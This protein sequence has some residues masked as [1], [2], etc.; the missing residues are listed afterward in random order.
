MFHQKWKDS[1]KT[2]VLMVSSFQ[3]SRNH[4]PKIGNRNSSNLSSRFKPIIQK[5]GWCK[6]S[7]YSTIIIGSPSDTS[8]YL[9]DLSHPKPHSPVAC[10]VSRTSKPWAKCR[11]TK[12]CSRSSAGKRAFQPWYHCK[13]SAKLH[14][15]WGRSIRS[16][17]KKT[18][19]RYS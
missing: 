15:S 6:S 11:C 16:R 3:D 14:P 2:H 19:G 17:W 12:I 13:T 4:Q 5:N 18:R 8:I 7:L 9:K 1:A 10:W